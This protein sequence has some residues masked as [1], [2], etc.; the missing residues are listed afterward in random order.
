MYVLTNQLLAESVVLVWKKKNECDNPDFSDLE[1]D[2]NKEH[3]TC[4]KTLRLHIDDV[5]DL[6]WS[7][8]STHLISGSVDNTAIMWNIVTGKYAF[9]HNALI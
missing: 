2:D 1:V 9:I 3:W 5:Y 8:D 6:C 7:S 4:A